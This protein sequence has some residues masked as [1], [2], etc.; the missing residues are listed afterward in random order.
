MSDISTTAIPTRDFHGLQ[1]PEAGTYAVDT[2]HSELTFSVRHMMVSKVRGRFGD[3]E[4]T[5]T[6][7]EDPLQS[8]VEVTIAAASVDT[9]TPDRDAHLT[10]PDFFD[11]EAYPHITFRSTGISDVKG[12]TFTLAGD[13]TVKD[14]TRPV[15]FTV[16]Y[17]GA[18]KNPWGQVVA[19][20]EGR[21]EIDREDFGLTWN[22]A[23]ETGGVLV[24]KVAT[25]DIAVEIGAAG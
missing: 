11:V 4:G 24:G 9:G 25:I 7:A 18:G 20:F 23:L 19:G 8:S 2:S 12:D 22:Q 1:I 6:I 3:V 17:N 15:S 16:T 14:V 13:L 5:V 21:I 10:S